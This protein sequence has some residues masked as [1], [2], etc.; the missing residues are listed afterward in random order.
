MVLQLV[1][2][3]LRLA[4]LRLLAVQ[5]G[6]PPQVMTGQLPPLLLLQ[7]QSGVR[8]RVRIS[9]GRDHAPKSKHYDL[10]S[11]CILHFGE[12]VHLITL[13]RE[14]YWTAVHSFGS[15]GKALWDQKGVLN[16]CSAFDLEAYVSWHSQAYQ[17]K[18]FER[19]IDHP[20]PVCVV[21][22]CIGLS[23]PYIPT[24]SNKQS[25]IL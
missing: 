8:L 20:C 2:S 6:M 4:L 12:R 5:V 15:Q 11:C 16:R 17:F 13:M 25:T 1:L 23:D 9:L 19:G 7:L 10:L 22:T 24:T 3:L 18:N 21:M 14:R